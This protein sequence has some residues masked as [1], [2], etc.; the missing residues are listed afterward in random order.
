MT[1]SHCSVDISSYRKDGNISWDRCEGVG[2]GGPTDQQFRSFSNLNGK[3]S[4][5]IRKLFRSTDV[6]IGDEWSTFPQNSNS[7]MLVLKEV[8]SECAAK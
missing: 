6:K 4:F 5:C 3:V 7:M 8:N 1:S 2:A